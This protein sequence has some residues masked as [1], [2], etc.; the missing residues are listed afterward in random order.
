MAL[1]G[2][3]QKIFIFRVDGA[4]GCNFLGKGWYYSAYYDT[5]PSGWGRGESLRWSG[6]HP[7]HGRWGKS[8]KLGYIG[9]VPLPCSAHYGKPWTLNY[10]RALKFPKSKVLVVYK[11]R[12]NK[13]NTGPYNMVILSLLNANMNLEYV[14]D[15]YV[16]QTFNII[17]W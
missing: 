7:L 6:E 9:R 12:L 5:G 13:V 3:G 10:F 4:G 17:S 11:K 15:I 8:T 16:M 1:V 2:G 14:T